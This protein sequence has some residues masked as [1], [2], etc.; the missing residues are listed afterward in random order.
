MM[1]PLIKKRM[2]LLRAWLGFAIYRIRISFFRRFQECI[3]TKHVNTRQNEIESFILRIVINL[4]KIDTPNL[5]RVFCN[6]RF[7]GSVLKTIC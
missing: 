2:L 5:V 1:Y 4:N 3:S 6:N 7:V